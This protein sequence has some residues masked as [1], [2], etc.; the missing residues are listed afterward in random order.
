ML[1]LCLRTLDAVFFPLH[2]KNCKNPHFLELVAAADVWAIEAH[3]VKS[4]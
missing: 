3:E 4:M 2:L 1:R